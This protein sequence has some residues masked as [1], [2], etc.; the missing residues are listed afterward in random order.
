MTAWKACLWCWIHGRY[1]ILSNPISFNPSS[2]N[3]ILPFFISPNPNSAI[4]GRNGTGRCRTG[5][6]GIKR[7]G[8]VQIEGTLTVNGT[9]FGEIELGEMRLGKLQEHH[10]GCTRLGFPRVLYWDQSFFILYTTPLSSLIS[11]PE[12]HNHHLRPQDLPPKHH[13][14][15]DDTQLYISFRP[16]T[17]L[18]HNFVCKNNCFKLILDD[19]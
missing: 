3:P 12:N 15:A 16:G 1:L 18:M 9:R 17:S 5:L 11:Q 4:L 14:Y 7:N 6:S 13:L 10:W 2:P 8:I 19:F